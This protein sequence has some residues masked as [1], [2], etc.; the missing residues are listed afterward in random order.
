MNP[1]ITPFHA[2]ILGFVEGLTE[3]L[4]V[5][6]TGHL[7]LTSHWLGL[8][9]RD[10][11]VQAFEIVIQFGAL[12]AVIGLYL[13]SIRSMAL[14]VM[15]KDPK[16]LTL[17]M[18]LVTAFLPAAVIGFLAEHWIKDKL[19]RPWPVVFALAVGGA[20]MIVLERRRMRQ[21][22]GLEEAAHRGLAL[23]SM[24]LRAALIIGLAQCLA[25]WPGTSRSMITIVA[26][27]LLGFSPRAAAEFSFLLALPT[28]GAATAY[29]LMK[30]H[31][32]IMTA[33]GSL[34]LVIGLVVSFI[35]AWVAVKGFLAYLTRHGMAL[36]GWYRV[37][38]AVIVIALIFWGGHSAAGF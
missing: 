21:G 35:V 4:P 10:P 26:A 37:I 19:F 9:Y 28:L 7:I 3:F 18:Q 22:A 36:F 27:L 33:T 8:Q 16:G 13:K 1:I 20:L 38:L 23:S 6:S 14:G 15:G 29:E 24:T 2:T 11:G 17:A 25:M 12:L 5:S 30:D 34:G 31:H 32:S